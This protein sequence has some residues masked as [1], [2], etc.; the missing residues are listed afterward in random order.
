MSVI[1]PNISKTG[2]I[3][4]TKCQ[5]GNVN[6]ILLSDEDTIVIT[7]GGDK[8]IKVESTNLVLADS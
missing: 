7:A 2:A 8:T 6:Q 3:S 5:N 1:S 4:V